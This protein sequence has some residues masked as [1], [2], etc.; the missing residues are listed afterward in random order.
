MLSIFFLVKN[1]RITFS[2]DDYCIHKL[3]SKCIVFTESMTS[4][5]T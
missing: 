4:L 2:N 5:N 3:Y 1:Q